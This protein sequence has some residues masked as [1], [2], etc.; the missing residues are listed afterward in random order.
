MQPLMTWMI[1]PAWV[2]WSAASSATG[3]RYFSLDNARTSWYPADVVYHTCHRGRCLRD[4]PR[5]CGLVQPCVRCMTRTA[6]TP[7]LAD[8]GSQRTG[9]QHTAFYG[10]LIWSGHP[11]RLPVPQWRPSASMWESGNLYEA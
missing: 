4:F 2:L 10:V 7:L 9:P 3:L 11:S 8:S 5:A 1:L 6:T